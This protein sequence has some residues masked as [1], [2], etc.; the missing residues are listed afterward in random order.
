MLQPK[1]TKLAVL[2]DYK[3]GLTFETGESGIFDTSPYIQGSWFGRLSDPEYF[4]TVHIVDE[5]KGIEWAD[6]QDIAPHELHELMGN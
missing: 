1:I 3:L 2:P 5:G 4:K 6:G